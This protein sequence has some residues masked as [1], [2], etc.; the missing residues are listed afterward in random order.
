MAQGPLVSFDLLVL[1]WARGALSALPSSPARP[2]Q[3]GSHIRVSQASRGSPFLGKY[4]IDECTRCRPFVS[5]MRYCCTGDPLDRVGP[6]QSFPRFLDVLVALRLVDVGKHKLAQKSRSRFMRATYFLA[7]SA[8]SP[9][10]SERSSIKIERTSAIGIVSM[11]RSFRCGVYLLC[12][13]ILKRSLFQPFQLHAQ[14]ILCRRYLAPSLMIQ[15]AAWVSFPAPEAGW[16]EVEASTLTSTRH[17]PRI[18]SISLNVVNDLPAIISIASRARFASRLKL[19]SEM[20]WSGKAIAAATANLSGVSVVQCYLGRL[21]L[22]CAWIISQAI[23]PSN[24]QPSACAIDLR[25][26]DFGFSNC[27]RRLRHQL[28]YLMQELRELH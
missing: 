27:S 21:A 2:D 3:L 18:L 13:V 6:L 16:S 26:T 14:G 8:S 9:Y 20:V 7:S 28:A 17:R 23:Q 1:Y 22:V 24:G 10:K 11:S 15:V 19:L 25:V 12:D 4:Y 5:V